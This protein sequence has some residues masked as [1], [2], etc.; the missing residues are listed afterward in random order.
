MITFSRLLTTNFA[1]V[2]SF[3]LQSS[4]T[5]PLH[6]APSRF[7]SAMPADRSRG[8]TDAMRVAGDDSVSPASER[9]RPEGLIELR[10]DKT[11]AELVRTGEIDWIATSQAG[12]VSR[13]M[14]ERLGTEKVARATT[15]V[16]F[17]PN[18]SFPR[19][20]HDGGEEFLVLD[21]V[22][23]D[24]YG[25]FG[26]YSYIRNYIGSGHTP[27]IGEEGCVILVKL[28]QMSH[29]SKGEPEHRNW[30]GLTPDR[31]CDEG[32]TMDEEG[33]VKKLSL[34]SS[35][36]ESTSVQVWPKESSLVIKVPKHGAELFVVDGSFTSQLLG[37]HD[38]RSWCRIPNDG[39][40]VRDFHVRTLGEDVYVWVKEGH[41]ASD[42]IGM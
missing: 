25:S 37:D 2:S 40:E 27:T 34:F 31:V 14:I 9:R 38:E 7:A 42:E 33:V 17:A 4:S 39:E 22:W 41:L 20:S 6:R 5:F 12:G 11:R 18:Q 10:S 8:S 36:L 23:R 28:R 24:D 1:F 3:R 29:L 26:K 16:R 13:K 19:H 30:V 35:P 15:I 32:R 21:G